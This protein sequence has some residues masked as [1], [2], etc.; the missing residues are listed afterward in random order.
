MRMS[1]NEVVTKMGGWISKNIITIMFMSIMFCIMLSNTAFATSNADALWNQVHGLIGKW[2][3]RLGGVVMFIGF[4]MFGLGWK[5]D[6]AEGK[7]RG[8]STI[9]A[10]G[11]V[12]GAAAMIGTFFNG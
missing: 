9:I 5:N 8:I 6:D 2:V 11:I 3:T 1:F 7:S 10:G 12:G 4:V